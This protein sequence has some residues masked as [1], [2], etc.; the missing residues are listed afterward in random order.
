MLSWRVTRPNDEQIFQKDGYRN[1]PST[2][3][4]APHPTSCGKI[5]LTHKWPFL[6]LPTTKSK[7]LSIQFNS[8]IACAHWSSI[9]IKIG[10]NKTWFLIKNFIIKT[11]S[12]YI[13]NKEVYFLRAF[14]ICWNDFRKSLAKNHYY[15][16]CWRSWS[17][18]DN[19]RQLYI[20][21]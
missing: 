13:I 11:Q 20:S 1:V 2:R 7:F 19:C 3:P 6:I 10:R 18:Y 8:I 9:I 21:K 16:Y 17:A 15:K 5:F 12:Y 14:I 4:L